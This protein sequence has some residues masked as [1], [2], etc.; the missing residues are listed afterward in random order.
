[1]A[2]ILIQD[3]SQY[4]VLTDGIDLSLDKNTQI[5]QGRKRESQY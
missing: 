4:V 2:G 5:W 1:M 3:D